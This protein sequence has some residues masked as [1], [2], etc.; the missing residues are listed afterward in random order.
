MKDDF[1]STKTFIAFRKSGTNGR[2][3][4]AFESDYP[5]LRS[6]ENTWDVGNIVRHH[7]SV[8][9][10]V[11]VVEVELKV[12]RVLDWGKEETKQA[13]EVMKYRMKEH[14]RTLRNLEAELKI[15]KEDTP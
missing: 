2:F 11:E 15:L 1:T 12:T 4:Q 7:E 6:H 10:P 14:R 9:T 5:V 3:L 13:I 8:E